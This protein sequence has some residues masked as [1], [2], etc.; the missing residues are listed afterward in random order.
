MHVWTSK[1]LRETAVTMHCLNQS[2]NIVLRAKG[3]DWTHS[4][5]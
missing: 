5:W 2:Q 4:K 3:Q 1:T